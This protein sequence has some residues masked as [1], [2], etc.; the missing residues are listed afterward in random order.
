MERLLTEKEAADVVRLKVTTLQQWRRK[1]VGPKYVKA[2]R[3][4]RYRREDLEEYFKSSVVDPE[5]K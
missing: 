1:G 5:Q 4:V 3:T 2:E